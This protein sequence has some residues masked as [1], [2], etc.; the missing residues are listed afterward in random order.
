MAQRGAGIMRKSA[1]KLAAGV[2]LGCLLATG[3]AVAEGALAIGS[4][5]NVSKD[6]IAYGGA[7]N[8]ATRQDA[9]DAAIATCRKWKA[10]KAAARCELVT[11]FTRECYAVANDPKAGTPGTGWATANDKETA[12]QRALAACRATA[13]P[14]R[15]EFCVVDQSNCDN[16]VGSQPPP[17]GSAPGSG[18]TPPGN[19]GR[20]N[21]D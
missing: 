10:P 2:A 9:I 6:G 12:G 11:T 21:F 17:I 18:G 15:R 14:G 16:V 1:S 8:H 7:Y 13:G 5:G 20:K 19:S 3:A 4:T